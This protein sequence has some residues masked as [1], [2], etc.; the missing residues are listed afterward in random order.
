MNPVGITASSR[1]CS[2]SAAR[3]DGVVDGRVGVRHRDD[4]AV[5]A[6]GGGGGARRDRLL[7]LPSGGAQVDVRV[8]E[9]GRQHEPSR[10]LTRGLDR[11]DHAV[12]DG[13]VVRAVQA[14]AGVD[15]AGSAHHEAVR[16]TLGVEQHHATS[17][18]EPPLRR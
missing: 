15:H 5:A 13:H 12:V 16:R 7:V 10:G 8:D 4:R 2:T 18:G 3:I 11:G 6:R 9:G 1:A 14:F 17:S